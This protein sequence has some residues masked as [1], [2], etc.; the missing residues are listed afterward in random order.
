MRC[1]NNKPTVKILLLICLCLVNSF[2]VACQSKP[3]NVAAVLQPCQELVDKEDFLAVGKCY[4][5]QLAANPQFAVEMEATF[6]KSVFEKCIELK[7]K[8]SYEKAIVCFEGA[9]VLN[10]NSANTQ[11]LLARSYYEYNKTKR[12]NDIEVLDRAENAI[13]S[14]LQI[15]PDDAEAYYVYGRIMAQKG[16][17]SEAIK[18]YQQA[19]KLNPKEAFFW[20]KLALIQEEIGDT[21]SALT[22]YYQV[23]ILDPKNT[24]ALYNSANLYE[25]AGDVGQAIINFEKLLEIK[26]PYDDAEERLENLKKQGPQPKQR[27]QPKQKTKT[28]GVPNDG[29][30]TL[31]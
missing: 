11:F 22:N 19:T 23:L 3:K 18:K 2:S 4:N 15:K 9:S 24:L 1:G 16:E 29:T 8:E 31:P 7:D 10:S 20:L 21:S 27:T 6:F 13:K 28:Q 25:K 12:R 26:K 5:E 14:S 30:S 17:T